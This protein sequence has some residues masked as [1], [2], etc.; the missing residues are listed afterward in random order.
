M[1][2]KHTMVEALPKMVNKMEAWN[3]IEFTPQQQAQSIANHC[4]TI[5]TDAPH[6]LE[7]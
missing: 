3:I 6:E 4:A 1:I 7:S 2:L 5:T